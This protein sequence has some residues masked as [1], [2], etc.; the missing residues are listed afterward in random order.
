M[1]MPHSHKKNAG[2]NLS[3]VCMQSNEATV[4]TEQIPLISERVISLGGGVGGV[5]SENLQ[6]I[7]PQ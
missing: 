2:K 7:P 3:A 4:F 1:S 6:S 5:T